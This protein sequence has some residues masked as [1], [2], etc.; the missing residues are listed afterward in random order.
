MFQNRAADA[1]EA[2]P[3]GDDSEMPDL[4]DF[5]R[6]QCGGL[7]EAF[8]YLDS[9]HTGSI[10]HDQFS[11]GLRLLQYPGDATAAFKEICSKKGLEVVKLCD[12]II[13]FATKVKIPTNMSIREPATAVR[14]EDSPALAAVPS[15]ITAM[16]QAELTQVANAAVSQATACT[17]DEIRLALDE[18]CA[19]AYNTWNISATS[20]F[21]LLM[22][23][24]A[25]Q[26]DERM[27]SLEAGSSGT[28]ALDSGDRTMALEQRLTDL[29]K[30]LKGRMLVAEV[31]VKGLGNQGNGSAYSTSD[32][33]ELKG[34]L[35]QAFETQRGDMDEVL[36]SH[37]QAL[38]AMREKVF[39]IERQLDMTTQRAM[40]G[41]ETIMDTID[42]QTGIVVGQAP[43]LEGGESV[44]TVESGM[45]FPP[46]QPLPVGQ[47]LQAD[48]NFS[49]ALQTLRKNLTAMNSQPVRPLEQGAGG[50]QM[51]QIPAVAANPNV[52]RMPSSPLRARSAMPGARQQHVQVP[53][54]QK[55]ARSSTAS[56]MQSLGTAASRRSQSSVALPTAQ[57]PAYLSRQLSRHVTPVATP[58]GNL[59]TQPS[60]VSPSAPT[61]QVS[62]PTGAQNRSLTP[63]ISPRS[64]P[65]RDLLPAKKD[66]LQPTASAIV[67][68][69]QSLAVE[70]R[71]SL[72]TASVPAA[73]ASFEKVQRGRLL[74]APNS[75]T[76]LPAQR[77]QSPGPTPQ[78][79]AAVMRALSPSSAVVPSP[80]RVQPSSLSVNPTVGPNTATAQA[81]GP[82]SPTR[83]PTTV[84]PTV[85]L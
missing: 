79:S 33:G 28:M 22:Q 51:E 58:R 12:F 24:F 56:S 60:P 8:S 43:A 57:L 37:W 9:E 27:K 23:N 34:E 16:W 7:N 25:A 46:G 21:K 11:T 68:R 20:E 52:Q 26:F 10:T 36:A 39:V 54:V 13:Y 76:M 62:S 83:L 63:R 15:E 18:A 74:P 65:R 19:S 31:A 41:I 2:C 14:F 38:E 64:A 3:G 67:E 6:T 70:R 85:R 32:L 66:L 29:E 53:C 47:A 50:I 80:A 45:S 49:E 48:Q 35:E 30:E 5:L 84:S 42:C 44:T 78:T 59:P 69:M 40:D 82:G 17:K 1:S 77:Y 73:T 61:R 71:Q 81:R 72:G 75:P 4:G 55:L